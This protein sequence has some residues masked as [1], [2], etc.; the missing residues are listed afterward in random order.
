MKSSVA[1]RGYDDV[2]KNDTT[3]IWGFFS[4][5]EEVKVADVEVNWFTVEYS[6]TKGNA[7]VI[8]KY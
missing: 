8:T 3:G 4:L 2:Q 6:S 1:K 7:S 5:A